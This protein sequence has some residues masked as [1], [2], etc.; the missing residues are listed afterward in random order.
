MNFQSMIATVAACAVIPGVAEAA[1]Q[2]ALIADLKVTMQGAVPL[3]RAKINGEE[4]SLIADSGGFFS[5]LSEGTVARFKLPSE[6]ADPSVYEIGVGGKQT[7]SVTLVKTFTIAGQSLP[8]VPFTVIDNEL[9]AGISGFIGQS[10]LG[11][12]DADY[13]LANGSI[14]LLR[15]KGCGDQRL[16]VWGASRPFSMIPLEGIDGTFKETIGEAFVN[17]KR[18]R[19]GFDTGSPTSA[20]SLEAARRVGVATDGPGVMPAGVVRGGIGRQWVESWVAPVA[21][22]KIGDEEVRN[23]KLRVQASSLPEVDMLLGADFFLSH[24]VYVANSQRRIYFTYNGGP[25]FNLT[26]A[27]SAATAPPH[28][29]S[30]EPTDADGFSRRG[31]ALAA[32][33]QFAAAIADLTRATTMARTEASYFTE[34]AEVY[35]EGGQPSLAMADLDRALKL[36]PD[37]AQARVA[38]A[39]LRMTAGQDAA[40]AADLAEADR[41]LPKE[42]DLRLTMAQLESADAG[43]AAIGQYDLWIK[44]H[45]DDNRMAQALNGRCW[46]RALWNIDTDKALADCDGALRRDRKNADF[47]DSRGLTHLRLGENDRAIADYDAAL[48]LQPKIVWSLYGRGI[49]KLRKGLAAD[50]QADLTAATALDPKVV[51]YARDRG[52]DR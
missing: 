26:T 27:P 32:R 17:G 39:K 52:L 23:T 50:G 40:A 48:A 18:V 47:L 29:A 19:V 43:A 42:A 28:E 33:R 13:D 8:N 7:I 49:A 45:P 11:F 35:V 12:A 3:V 2:A 20:L 16:I 41:I 38:R 9:G 51:A 44:A 30:A 22:F 37:D 46:I 10:L 1:C 15:P 14:R 34:R 31:M 21:S 36:K 6:V 4:V 24:Q 25:V 5:A